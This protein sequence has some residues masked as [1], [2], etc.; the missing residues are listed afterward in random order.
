MNTPPPSSTRGLQQGSSTADRFP[1]AAKTKTRRQIGRPQ[2]R[3]HGTLLLIAAL[4]ALGLSL[5]ASALTLYE[6]RATY[7]KALDHLTAG[8]MERF[9]DLR[10]DLEDYALAPY[11]DYYELQSR[12]SSA[13]PE[14]V[15][16]FRASHSALPVADIVYYRWLKRLGGQ[17][18]WQ[19]FLKHYEGSEDAELRC[20]ELRALLST[21]KKKKALDQVEPLWL[22]AKSQPKACDPLFESWIDA[23]R[24][25]ESMVWDRLGLALDANSRTLARYLQRFFESPNV[26]PWAQSYYNVHVTPSGVT[27]TS[28][29][30]TDTR[31]SREVIAHGLKRL[32]RRDVEAASVAWL[33][34]QDSHSFEA[35][36]ASAVN[37]AI[38]LGHAKEGRFPTHDIV[39]TADFELPADE[40]ALAAL[41][42]QSWPDLEFWIGRLDDEA[43]Q[44]RRWQYWFARAL[45]ETTYEPRQAQLTFQALAD[46][47][48]YYGFLAAERL[49]QPV[50][51]NHQPTKVSPL[52]INR[53]RNQLAVRR[54]TELYAVGDRVNARREWYRLLS[55]LTARDKATAAT[56]A[57]TIGWT[58]QGIR[59]ANAGDLR[60]ALELRFP[61]PYADEFQRI[62]HVT[63]VPDNFLLAVARQE[64]LFDPRARSSA[65][66]RGLMQLIH[67]T[68]ER[69]ARRIGRSAPSASDLYDPALNIELGGH[70]LAD[71]MGRYGDRRPLAA[72]AYNAGEHRVDR[73]IRDETGQ[74]MDVWIETIPF[75][76]TRNYVKNVMAFTQ[77]YG[78][79]RGSPR[80]MLEAHEVKL[81]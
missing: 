9:D 37:R 30:T 53:L 25:T 18:R 75:R 79:R 72:A 23:G 4:M 28:R 39:Q 71:L 5:P 47:R 50:R 32:A 64:S 60:D 15:M 43:R 34:Y 22:V 44:D 51:L 13:K 31:Y 76:E 77:V 46:Q 6:Q 66:A 55:D 38:L 69:V 14:A 2:H 62:S 16:A 36:T 80:P 49:G 67:P 21:G 58:S 61:E 26:K 48:D 8:R 70:H 7:K 27:Q 73:W 19:T 52:A 81:P 65:N 10:S 78:Q 57:S 74:W 63:T 3:L 45:M 33:S 12:L 29:F 59:T 42:H 54:A 41:T 1:P 56:L 17:R 24:L 35:E 11:L 68:A 40:L 20:Y